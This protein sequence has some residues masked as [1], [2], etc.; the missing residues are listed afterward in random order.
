M[1]V[2]ITGLPGS[3]KSLFGAKKI[4]EILKH[5]ERRV[6]CNFH[7]RDDSCEFALWD[8]MCNAG[9][10]LCV[11]DEAQVWFP[12]R[13]CIQKTTWQD[14]L[15]FQQHRKNGLDLIWIAQDETRIDVALRELTAFK[16]EC[17]R[18]WRLCWAK[19]MTFAQ[20]SG[21]NLGTSFYAAVPQLWDFYY[22]HEIIGDRDGAG[23]EWGLANEYSNTRP[24][25][26]FSSAHLA[27]YVKADDYDLDKK[28]N[29]FLDH[30]A[31]VNSLPKDMPRS[32]IQD[33]VRCEKGYLIDGR[34]LPKVEVKPS[35]G[36]IKRNHHGEVSGDFDFLFSP[37]APIVNV[38]VN[39]DRKRRGLFRR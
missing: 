15:A 8:D 20:G 3:G 6:L 14:L 18:F 25:F 29:Q 24:V 27:M 21:E 38:T 32:S 39:T 1:I 22:T 17:H 23:Y 26:R 36:K 7:V 2:G 9:N 19:K 35:T 37:P 5:S 10:A 11:I 34:F 28:L 31:L 4:K 30:V 12:S 33:Y 16:Y 13:G